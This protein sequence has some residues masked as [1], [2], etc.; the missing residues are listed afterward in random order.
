[1]TPVRGSVLPTFRPLLTAISLDC[2]DGFSWNIPESSRLRYLRFLKN[3]I[4]RILAK[5]AKKWAKRSSKK[6]T[7]F[8]KVFLPIFN[9]VASLS[10]CTTFVRMNQ[11]ILCHASLICQ[12]SL[13][14]LVYLKRHTLA[15]IRKELHHKWL[16][17]LLAIDR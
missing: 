3:K 16:I 15:S 9:I 1:M 2:L 8:E 11:R 14:K 7:F 5:R 12:A 6:K 17:C 13:N 4:A 10:L